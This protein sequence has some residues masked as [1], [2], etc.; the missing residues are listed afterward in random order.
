MRSQHPTASTAPNVNLKKPGVFGLG[1]CECWSSQNVFNLGVDAAAFV[2]THN[3]DSKHMSGSSKESGPN[4][5]TSFLLGYGQSRPSK[6]FAKGEQNEFTVEE[7][8]SA[9]GTCL[10]CQPSAPFYTNSLCPGGVCPQPLQPKPVPRMSGMAIDLQTEYYNEAATMPK[11]E[12][13]QW[14]VNNHKPPYAVHILRKTEDWT[15]LGADV[16]TSETPVSR[17]DMDTYRYGVLVRISPSKGVISKFDFNVVINWIVNATVLLSFPGIAVS[18]IIFNLCGKRSK[19]YEKA[20]G[21]TVTVDS[22]YKQF[23]FSSLIAN[24][25]FEKLDTKGTGMVETQVLQDAF[26]ALLR[27]KMLAKHPGKKE[28]ASDQIK[29]FVERLLARDYHPEGQ[30]GEPLMDVTK[31]GVSHSAF[32]KA[33]T[34]SEAFDW[35]DLMAIVENPDGDLGPDQKLVKRISKKKQKSSIVQVVPAES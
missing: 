19:L 31:T 18:Y 20:N 32:I 24:S 13:Y 16:Q 3:Y 12:S 23:A 14:I 34:F 11:S 15:S 22:M 4:D 33:C 1:M 30:D 6:I 7:V 17:V 28:W 27:P 2:F 35:E 26:I 9:V 5:P 8:L 10:D 21:K 29:L 25:F